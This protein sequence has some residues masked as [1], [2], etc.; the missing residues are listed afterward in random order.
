VPDVG[1]PVDVDV[2]GASAL[3]DVG[4]LDPGDQ[5]RG[6]TAH[7]AGLQAEALSPVEVD[8]HLDLR[9]RGEQLGLRGFDTGHLRNHVLE[10]VR[11]VA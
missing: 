8:L 11:D 6:R 4:D 9:D 3:V 5:R 1:D 10:P 7:V 2:V